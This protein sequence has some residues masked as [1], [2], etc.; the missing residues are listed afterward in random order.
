MS[1]PGVMSDLSWLL[2]NFADEVTG[3]AHVAVV[4]SDGLLLAASRSLPHDRA[5]QLAT[6]TA[7]LVSLA[8]G[9]SRHFEGGD[10]QQTMVHMNKGHLII[11]S[12]GD[13]SALVVLAA[14]DCDVGHVGYEMA[15][16]VDRV[17]KALMPQPRDAVPR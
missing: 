4:S 6:I 7:G 15:L 14:R 9:T 11:M 16:L 3:I 17:G 13:G 2:D 1:G 5:M 12:I 8:S 10:V